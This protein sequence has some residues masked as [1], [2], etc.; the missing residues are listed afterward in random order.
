M[1]GEATGKGYLPKSDCLEEIALPCRAHRLRI[2][3]SC[4]RIHIV[5]NSTL[6]YFCLR[7]EPFKNVEA[8]GIQL[9]FD[10]YARLRETRHVV[11]R[12]ITE[13]VELTDACIGRRQPGQA[14]RT[15]W[16]FERGIKSGEIAPP[17][18]AN[19]VSQSLIV[20]LIGLTVLLNARPQRS[21]AENTIQVILQTLG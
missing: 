18:D 14:F 12:L 8:A 10:V 16:Q 17:I 1:A 21:F 15:R 4:H 6:A 13:Y 3:R 19:A 20:S 7:N 11:N 2:K 5:F 9:K